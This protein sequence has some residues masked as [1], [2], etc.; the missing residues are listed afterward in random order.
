MSYYDKNWYRKIVIAGK[1]E[2]LRSLGA[3]G[4]IIAFIEEISL[5]NVK[6]ANFLVNEF[7]KNPSMNL[8][9]LKNIDL[10]TV[11]QAYS[12][13]ERTIIERF[14]DDRKRSGEWAAKHI[15]KLYRKMNGVPP[16]VS[17]WKEYSE[18]VGSVVAPMII[19]GQTFPIAMANITDWLNNNPDIDINNF[20]VQQ[21]ADA[22]DVWHKEMA[23]QGVGNFYRENNVIYGPE[24]INKDGEKIDE[25]NGWTIQEIKTENDLV[26]EGNRMNH[27][28]GSSSYVRGLAEGR[29][30][31]FSLRDP[32]NEPHVTIQT[33][34]KGE[35]ALQIFGASNSDPK[36]EYKEMI[37]NWNEV[38]NSPMKSYY[39]SNFEEYE[40]LD[41]V[42]YSYRTMGE[43]FSKFMFP[44][45]QIDEYGFV[46]TNEVD[47]EHIMSSLYEKLG[48]K[49]STSHGYIGDQ[50][51]SRT[52]VEHAFSKDERNLYD[53]FKEMQ[54][55]QDLS[56][57]E[58]V[59][60]E[61]G[62]ER[63]D[64]DNYTDPS[65]YDKAME[66][67]S[68][69]EDEI[70]NT[71]YPVAWV[72]N[73][74]E[75]FIEKLKE[76]KNMSLQTYYSEVAQKFEAEDEEKKKKAREE[77]ERKRRENPEQIFF[78]NTWYG[79]I[80]TSARVNQYFSVGYQLPDADLYIQTKGSLDTIGTITD[81]AEGNIGLKFNQEFLLPNYMK[82]FLEY[83][84][85][86]GTWRKYAKGMLKLQHLTVEGV[87]TAIIEELK[88]QNP[89]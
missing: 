15:R 68:K 43:D 48:P 47:Y 34:E 75:E 3:T 20:N 62:I 5:D 9:Q 23:E 11:P 60:W 25:W 59:D 17:K 82:Y 12:E 1:A 2:Y 71:Q 85:M 74:F 84:K 69:E 52:L 73:I 50:G 46:N 80:K 63:P 36:P 31:I 76:T 37:K 78:A 35:E 30:K 65:E 58:S 28:V 13:Y 87:E 10:P 61:T 45:N 51:I 55:L 88:A 19:N 42:L 40:D 83:M 77:Y 14:N 4:D 44:D 33:D 49:L 70:K 89:Q 16:D 38:G 72:N 21:A 27:C 54:K 22:S 18:W 26:T 39:Y 79:K 6:F 66:L 81:R 32:K 24:W 8:A 7:R 41:S 29:M 64:E 86:K 53:F 56:Y 67:F 57:E